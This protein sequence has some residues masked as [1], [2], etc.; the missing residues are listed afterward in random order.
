MMKEVANELIQ[1]PSKRGVRFFTP[2]NEE[3]ALIA[4]SEFSD[5]ASPDFN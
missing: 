2:F 5:M 1:I 4:K 3:R